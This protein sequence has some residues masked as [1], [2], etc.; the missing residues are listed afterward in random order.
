MSAPLVAG[1]CGLLRAYF[2]NLT[3]AEVETAIGKGAVDIYVLTPNLTHSGLGWRWLGA[4]R[5]NMEATIDTLLKY[6]HIFKEYALDCGAPGGEISVSGVTA[7]F[8]W[9]FGS[10]SLG[11]GNPKTIVNEGMHLVKVTTPNPDPNISQVGCVHYEDIMVYCD[12]CINNTDTPAFYKRYTDAQ[13]G[14]KVFTQQVLP[15]SQEVLILA[16]TNHSDYS[17]KHHEKLLLIKMDARGKIIWQKTINPFLES[18]NQPGQ[19]WLR[20]AALL[21]DNDAFYIV[22]SV[23]LANVANNTRMINSELLVKTNLSG[24]V[25]WVK[26]IKHYRSGGSYMGVKP[27]T[28]TLIDKKIFIAELV[29]DS[30]ANLSITTA[31]TRF[32]LT[33]STWLTKRINSFQAF[34]NIRLQPVDIISFHSGSNIRVAAIMRK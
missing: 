22:S 15:A 1:F 24:V 33:T 21:V 9:F 26:E 27:I 3:P 31:F 30:S 32:D 7:S 4:G 23:E 17:D 5:L 8:Q 12:P 34:N 29:V 11:T 2:P 25:Q 13:G 16:T 10:T 6:N 18:Y 19:T 20:P 14:F 28:A